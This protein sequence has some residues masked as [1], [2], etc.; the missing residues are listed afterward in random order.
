M[1]PTHAGT[2]LSDTG[3]ETAEESLSIIQTRCPESVPVPL[4]Y[5]K[6]KARGLEY[7]PNFQ[8]LAGIGIGKGE[9]LG[10]VQLPVSLEKEVSTLIYTPHF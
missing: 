3:S 2:R 4:F 5:Q 9:A 10:Q 8:G 1:D 7:G 6:L